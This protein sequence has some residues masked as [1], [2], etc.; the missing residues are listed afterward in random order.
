M[1]YGLANV[2]LFQVLWGTSLHFE[3][4]VYDKHFSDTQVIERE[5][6]RAAFAGS[7][8]SLNDLGVSIPAPPSNSSAFTER[9]VSE[10]LKLQSARTKEQIRRAKS[11]VTYYGWKLGS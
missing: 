11:Q 2:L 4:P 6:L 9:E 10:L 5:F 1:N 8:V 3:R 7:L